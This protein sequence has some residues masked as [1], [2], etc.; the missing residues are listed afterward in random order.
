MICSFPPTTSCVAAGFGRHGMLLPVSNPDLRPFDLETD[1]RVA[2]KVGNLPY[3]FGHARPLGSRTIC[4]V[5]DGRTDRR[6]GG[7]KSKAYCPLPCGQG[8]D[9]RQ[10]YRAPYTYAYRRLTELQF[11]LRGDS[12]AEFVNDLVIILYVDRDLCERR[13]Q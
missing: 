9:N 2:S 13:A 8:H 6:T 5:R 7:E 1:M 11:R 12:S 4:Y 10:M 3:K